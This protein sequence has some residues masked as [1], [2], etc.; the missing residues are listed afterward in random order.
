MLMISE[1]TGSVTL[2]FIFIRFFVYSSYLSL[3]VWRGIIFGDSLSIL[4]KFVF[5]I[6]NTAI[7]MFSFVMGVISHFLISAV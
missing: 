5:T 4:E 2:F 1:S 3:K 7:M 6:H